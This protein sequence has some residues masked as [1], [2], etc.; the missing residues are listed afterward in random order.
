MRAV[1]RLALLC[2]LAAC[3]SGGGSGG[4]AQTA[5]ASFAPGAPD[6]LEVRLTDRLP[7]ESAQLV[8]PDGRF[9]PAREIERDRIVEQYPRAAPGFGVGVFGGSSGHVGTSVG[10]GFPIGGYGSGPRETR[11]QSLARIPVGDMA[12]YRA[13]W[14]H[15]K[16]RLQVGTPEAGNARTMEIPAPRPPEG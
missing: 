16:I 8:A 7:L 1:L 13:G 14:Q 9:F 15:W 2:L 6:V 3:S 4:I 5:N 10:V 12:G 11:V